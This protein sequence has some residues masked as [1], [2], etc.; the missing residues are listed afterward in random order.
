MAI[1]P[2]VRDRFMRDGFPRRIGGI[3]AN[4]SRIRSFSEDSDGEELVAELLEETICFVAWTLA[5]ADVPPAT[6]VDLTRLSSQLESWREHLDS[7]WNSDERLTLSRQADNWSNELV[8]LSGL[9]D[10]APAS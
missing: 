4:M 6:E 2:K 7:I 3:S 5:D 9:L 8:A 1:H 10:T